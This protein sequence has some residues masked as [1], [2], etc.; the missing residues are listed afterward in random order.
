MNNEYCILQEIILSYWCEH[1]E[2]SGDVDM[3]VRLVV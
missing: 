3:D 2:V 1:V